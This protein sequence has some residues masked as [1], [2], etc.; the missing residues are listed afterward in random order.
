M[1]FPTSPQ[2]GQTS[3]VSGVTYTYSTTT[4][5]WTRSAGGITVTQANITNLKID[6]SGTLTTTE[7]YDLDDI[8]SLVDGFRNTFPLSYNGTRITS[9]TNPWALQVSV[10]GVA[11]PAFSNTADVTWQSG[12]LTANRG[13]TLDTTGNLKFA[14]SIPKGSQ[15]T[16]RTQTGTNIQA[17]RRYPFNALDILAGVI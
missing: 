7:V 2:N 15:I 1:S 12:I 5:A 3:V 17:P 6:G 16:V 8:T 14:D 11:Q 10:N 9:F 13:Y 4:N